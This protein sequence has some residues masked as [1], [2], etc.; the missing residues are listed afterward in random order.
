MKRLLVPFLFVGAVSPVFAGEV[1]CH[2][3]L[4][5]VHVAELL[6]A[7]PPGPRSELKIQTRCLALEYSVFPKAELIP[8]AQ[9]PRSTGEGVFRITVVETSDGH[10]ASG[11]TIGPASIRGTLIEPSEEPAFGLGAPSA[12]LRSGQ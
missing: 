4:G 12:V 10:S 11:L 2:R 8:P 3:Q 7:S 9:A 1:P 6:N 5:A